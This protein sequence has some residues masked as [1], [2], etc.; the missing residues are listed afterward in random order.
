MSRLRLALLASIMLVAVV[1]I[2]IFQPYSLGRVTMKPT[3][4]DGA[5]TPPTLKLHTPTL[6]PSTTHTPSM[7][8]PEG[9]PL[10]SWAVCNCVA[11]LHGC[12]MLLYGVVVRPVDGTAIVA[13]VL[14]DPTGSVSQTVGSCRTTT[15]ARMASPAEAEEMRRDGPALDLSKPPELTM[16]NHRT[17]DFHPYHNVMFPTGAYQFYVTQTK[18]SEYLSKKGLPP[19]VRITDWPTS[20]EPLTH[21]LSYARPIITTKFLEYAITVG[22]VPGAIKLLD[23]NVSATAYHSVG[24]H[25]AD[26]IHGF[27]EGMVANLRPAYVEEFKKF[28]AHLIERSLAEYGDVPFNETS[29]VLYNPR[30]VS[31]ETNSERRNRVRFIP[32]LAAED[33]GATLLSTTNGSVVTADEFVAPMSEYGRYFHSVRSRRVLFGAEGAFFVWMLVSKPETV[34]VVYFRASHD[35]VKRYGFF[36]VFTRMVPDLKMVVYRVVNGVSPPL[37][38]LER[39]VIEPFKPHQVKYVGADE[40]GNSPDNGKRDPIL[41][42]CTDDPLT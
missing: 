5:A 28:R 1:S 29:P 11:G 21:T 13:A 25:V 4:L 36:G 23:R 14:P 32:R 24:L 34:W 26:G 16:V 15:R 31:C 6:L 27:D 40:N 19:F 2:F 9:L 8:P 30:Q 37:E 42:N 3:D 7:I 17:W 41:T 20:I 18:M 12:S 35:A 39:A 38:Q 22:R 33:M 10:Q